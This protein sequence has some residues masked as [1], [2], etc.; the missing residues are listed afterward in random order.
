MQNEIDDE[1]EVMS[2]NAL[3]EMQKNQRAKSYGDLVTLEIRCSRVQEWL[4]AGKEVEAMDILVE[5]EVELQKIELNV[6]ICKQICQNILDEIQLPQSTKDA[7]NARHAEAWILIYEGKRKQLE[8]FTKQSLQCVSASIGKLKEQ[9]V[10]EE[11]AKEQLIVNS[12]RQ[13]E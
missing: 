10:K 4:N 8:D 13:N 1:F 11:L 2:L 6:N 3:E 7:F 12:K 9:I 5:I